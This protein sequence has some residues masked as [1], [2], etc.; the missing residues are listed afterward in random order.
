M[1]IDVIRYFKHSKILL[2]KICGARFLAI[3]TDNRQTFLFF[4]V[5][6][7]ELYRSC[8]NVERILAL[9]NLL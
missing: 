9:S 4:P 7:V 1:E 8:F 6:S 2:S 3:K 5:K